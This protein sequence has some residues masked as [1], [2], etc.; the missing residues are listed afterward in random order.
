M[1][2]G[3]GAIRGPRGDEAAA[4]SLKSPQPDVRA[5]AID[6]LVAIVKAQRRAG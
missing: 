6:A 4:G 1:I 2:A 3:A 5:A